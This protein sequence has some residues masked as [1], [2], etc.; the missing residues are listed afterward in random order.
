MKVSR[1]GTSSTTKALG[2]IPREGVESEGLSPV[3]G[4][5]HNPFIGVIP[6]EGVESREYAS[7]KR[8]PVSRISDPERGS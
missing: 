3:H 4:A 6:R 8:S 2:V 1:I 7:P 5:P